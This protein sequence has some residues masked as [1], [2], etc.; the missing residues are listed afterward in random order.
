LTNVAYN[1]VF[2]AVVG[3]PV[4][5]LSRSAGLP[6]WASA[7]AAVLALVVAWRFLTWQPL[8]KKQTRFAIEHQVKSLLLTRE[9]AGWLDIRHRTSPFRLRIFRESG[10][11]AAAELLVSVPREPW[12]AG[13]AAELALILERHNCA[14]ATQ[15]D[16]LR[17]Q[18]SCL[19]VTIQIPNIWD[20]AAG[21]G[22]AH[23]TR[24]VLDFF[25]IGPSE[26][27]DVRLEGE[28]SR[29][30]INHLRSANA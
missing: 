20:E 12:S 19:E 13:R 10:E 25:G 22:P 9:N 1:V 23:I 14:F 21:A 2:A 29:R 18:A 24:L 6:W 27:F 3:L 8:G 17:H 16:Q 7:I 4:I 15:Q 30:L 28:A 26:L 11:G 5:W